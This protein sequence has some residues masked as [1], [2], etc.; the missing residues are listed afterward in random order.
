MIGAGRRPGGVGRTLLRNI[1]AAG[2]TGRL[3]AVNHSFPDDQGTVDG[4]P[5]YRSITEIPEP[6]DLAVIAVPAERVPEAVADCG[7]HG[8]QGLLVVTS[9]Y[10]ESGSLEGRER[11]RALVRQ[12]RSYGMRVIGPNALG[13]L[14]TSPVVR[15]NASLSPELPPP[16]GSGCS[17][18]PGRSAS[19]C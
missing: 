3:H 8:V 4:A 12:A 15:L 10:A 6:V 18:S 17:P 7:E 19:P 1:A 9:G 16:G 13:I 11:Q 2:F 5:A 14:N